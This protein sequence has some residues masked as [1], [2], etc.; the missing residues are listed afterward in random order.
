M[1]SKVKNL[2]TLYHPCGD[3]GHNRHYQAKMTPH[4]VT[5]SIRPPRTAAR[6]WKRHPAAG[7]DC[8]ERIHDEPALEALQAHQRRL[9]PSQS[10]LNSFLLTT[11]GPGAP[12]AGQD[13]VLRTC[14]AAG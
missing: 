8:G 5:N 4:Q 14:W 1:R 3:I 12:N 13:R 9:S 10:W 2:L 6:C 11:A 7:L